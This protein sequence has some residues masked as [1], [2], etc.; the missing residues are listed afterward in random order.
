MGSLITIQIKKAGNQSV[1]G[2]NQWRSKLTNRLC[3]QRPN[4][5]RTILEPKS[6]S[7]FLGA[8]GQV[9]KYK[10]VSTKGSFQLRLVQKTSIEIGRTKKSENGESFLYVKVGNAE[11]VEEPFPEAKEHF[12]VLLPI[13]IP[14][15]LI[16]N[17]ILKSAKPFENVNFYIGKSITSASYP[18]ANGRIRNVRLDRLFIGDFSSII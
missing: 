3:L 11:R 16:N 5:W 12:R 7:Q 4:H 10:I 1:C 14:E 17:W 9:S 18:P 8:N 15:S 2:W 13:W 6:S